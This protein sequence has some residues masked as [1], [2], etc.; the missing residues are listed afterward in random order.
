MEAAPTCRRR[1]N[2]TVG[3][4]ATISKR[5]LTFM[6]SKRGERHRSFFRARYRAA[7]RSL[8]TKSVWRFREFHA[9]K[10]GRPSH[11]VGQR[12]SGATIGCDVGNF[13]VFS[14]QPAPCGA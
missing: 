7:S 4:I 8:G 2:E 6:T 14:G 10:L 13:A 9:Q 11:A 12:R 5:G 3:A 1:K